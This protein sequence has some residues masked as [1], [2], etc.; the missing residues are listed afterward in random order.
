[1]IR[2]WSDALNAGLLD[3]HGA[4]GAAFAYAAEAPPAR[5]V[6]L[7][8]PVRL[9]SWDQ[10][11]G[12]HPIFE[13]N[14][15]EGYLKEKLRLAFAKATG[16]FDSLDL[17]SI[18][19]RSQIGRLRY[20]APDAALD[21]Q[22]PFQSVD[23]VLKR[24]RDGELFDYMM[25]RFA[26]Y[27]GIAGVQPKVMIRDEKAAQVL[28]GRKSQSVQGATHIVKFWDPKEYPH[29]AANEYFCLLAAEKAG[30][31]VPRRRLSE[32][33][34]AL[35]VDRFDL[36]ADGSYMGIE[37]FC[38]LNGKGTEKKYEGGY[39]TA[40]FKRLKDFVPAEAQRTELEKL[41]TLFV[42]NA[43]VR[44]GDAH[45]KNFALTYDKVEGEAR[46]ADVYDIVTTTVYLPKDT[47]ALTLD[48]TPNWPDLK[49]LTRL[50]TVRCGLSPKEVAKIMDRVGT[51]VSE[52]RRDLR[53]YASDDP[54][55]V[56]VASAM[57]AQWETGMRQSLGTGGR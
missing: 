17:L 8:M 10:K 31:K 48:G 52:A 57:E 33:A 35:V 47:M 43:V 53:A 50:G 42:L 40:V 3:R 41:F 5:A 37:D 23:D 6:S 18:V 54:S 26:A 51:A 20:T 25:D 27:S 36:R 4:N 32:D 19:G 34:S 44:N 1:M 49:Q 15:P 21:D 16:T 24:R 13:M 9:A 14:L 2:V 55:F 22:V 28:D 12:I 46:L 39:E 11:F 45:L 7:T 30:L 38:V 56:D 29:L